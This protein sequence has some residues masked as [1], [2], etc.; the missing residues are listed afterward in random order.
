MEN[1]KFFACF[2]HIYK[3]DAAV[4]CRQDQGANMFML[5]VLIIRSIKCQSGMDEKGKTYIFLLKTSKPCETSAKKNRGQH[6]NTDKQQSFR[7][8]K[9]LSQHPTKTFKNVR[10]CRPALASPDLGFKRGPPEAP[11]YPDPGFD[12]P[13]KRNSEKN[14]QLSQQSTLTTMNESMDE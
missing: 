1:C 11:K 4:C 14:V 5:T 13:P 10:F 2:N 8:Y 9:S 12:F 6:K 3:R 7:A